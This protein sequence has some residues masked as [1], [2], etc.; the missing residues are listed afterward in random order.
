ME[1]DRDKTCAVSSTTEVLGVPGLLQF[2]LRVRNSR[3]LWLMSYICTLFSIIITLPAAF[4][5]TE[6][7]NEKK[8]EHFGVI[9][10]NKNQQ[11]KSEYL[12]VKIHRN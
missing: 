6:Y 1:R 7:G 3:N 4:S 10:E 11:N 12:D 9:S 2:L 8:Q 5:I